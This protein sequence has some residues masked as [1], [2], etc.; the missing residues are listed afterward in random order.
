VASAGL[1]FHQSDGLAPGE[2]TD[3]MESE[4]IKREELRQWA[5][6]PGLSG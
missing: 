4:V 1:R 2:V 5:N 3:V 6:Q